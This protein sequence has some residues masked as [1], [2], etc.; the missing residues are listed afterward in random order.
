MIQ[1]FISEKKISFPTIIP[2]NECTAFAWTTSGQYQYKTVQ[3]CKKVISKVNLLIT[4]G[5]VPT[6]LG[7]EDIRQEH[8][9][10]MVWEWA[11]LNNSIAFLQQETPNYPP[12]HKWVA[13]N[14]TFICWDNT[15][16]L[17]TVKFSVGWPVR[18]SHQS[19]MYLP[20]EIQSRERE[21]EPYGIVSER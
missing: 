8:G 15:S 1:H 16:T 20:K 3:I 14:V 21:K 2:L 17:V 5:W 13:E 7:T 19:Y 11:G 10:H 18:P 12:K 9:Y 6:P 4:S